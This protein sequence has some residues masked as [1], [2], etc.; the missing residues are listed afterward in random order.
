MQWEK[1]FQRKPTATGRKTESINH[2]VLGDAIACFK[3]GTGIDSV[4][5]SSCAYLAFL[6]YNYCIGI[7]R[8]TNKRDIECSVCRILGFKVHYRCQIRQDISELQ[9]VLL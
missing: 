7:P 1:L 4:L 9:K 2:T 3:E 5:N 8:T 6:I